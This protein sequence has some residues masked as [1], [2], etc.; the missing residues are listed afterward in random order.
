MYQQTDKKETVKKIQEYLYVLSGE[1][2]PKIPR[3]P[4]D[5][6]F[7]EETRNAVIKFQEIKGLEGNGIVDFNT[8]TALYKDYRELMLDKSTNG[9]IVGDGSFP[10]YETNQNEDVRALHIMINEL[11][12]IYPEITEVGIGSYF[13][14]KTARAIEDLRVIFMLP[15][16]KKL[17]KALYRRMVAE[18]DAKKRLSQKFQ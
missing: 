6:S 9:Y 1:K 15:P 5:G 11:R 2:Y 8:F 13:S 17:D 10:L 18:I 4:I 14:S 16:S 12:K 3:V 7:N